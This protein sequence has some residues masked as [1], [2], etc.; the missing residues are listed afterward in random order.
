VATK[1][2]AFGAILRLFDVALLDTTSDWGPALAALATV[3][4]LVGNVGAL[5]QSSLKRLLAWSSVAQAGY[6]LAGVVVATRLGVQATVFYLGVYLM[7]NVA[8]FAVI[9]IRER[10]TGLGDDIASVQGLGAERP[11]LAMSMTLAM[12]GLA[13]IPATAGFI[14]KFYLI[15][16]AVAGDYAWLGVVI[17]IGSMVSLAYY[18][19]VIAA[20]WMQDAPVGTTALATTAHPVMAGGSAEADTVRAQP[21]TWFVALLFGAAT[22][23]FGI[24]PSP[25]FDLAVDAGRSMSGLF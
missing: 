8:A 5:G 19:K 14:G 4:I 22:L 16:A 11:L 24:V 21:E 20:M 12:L 23:F 15:D 2:A 9:V 6:M 13:G 7:M 25:I 18:L 10:E 3:T 1:A 17:V